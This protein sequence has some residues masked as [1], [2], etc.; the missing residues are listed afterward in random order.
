[1]AAMNLKSRYYDKDITRFTPYR[2][3]KRILL[4]RFHRRLETDL[5]GTVSGRI[6]DIAII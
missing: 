1:M 5:S 6:P 4:K 2:E 3:V